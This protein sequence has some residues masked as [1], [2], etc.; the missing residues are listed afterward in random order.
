MEVFDALEQNTEEWLRARAGMPTASMF[1]TVMAKPGPRGGQP[2]TRTTYL[3]KLAGEIITGEPM[4]NWS[5]KY[6][7]LGHEMEPEA[8]SMYEMIVGEEV[9]QVGFIKNGNC[10]GSPD[11]LVGDDGIW[12]NK[13]AEPHIQIERLLKGTLPTEHVAQCQG[14]MMVSQ[15]LWVDFMSYCRGM[16]PLILRVERNERYIAELKIDVNNFVKELNAL[17]EKIR[18]M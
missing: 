15:R 13:N 12:E 16:P 3:Y 14:L 17:V 8:R 1:S 10:G 11:A 9:Q 6:M 18:G 7:E 4:K 5:N 2:K